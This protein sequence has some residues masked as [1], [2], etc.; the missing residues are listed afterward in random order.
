MS[1]ASELDDSDVDGG[2]GIANCYDESIIFLCGRQAEVVWPRKGKGRRA[3]PEVALDARG[4]RHISF[5]WAASI[6][7]HLQKP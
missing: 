1:P 2:E 6:I 5:N 7:Q 4:F 3:S